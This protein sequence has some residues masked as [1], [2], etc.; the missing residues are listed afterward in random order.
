MNTSFAHFEKLIQEEEQLKKRMEKNLNYTQRIPINDQTK[1]VIF[2]NY[3]KSKINII[4]FSLNKIENINNNT[5]A[6]T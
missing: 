4:L 6:Y 5:K 3:N 1:Y 2:P